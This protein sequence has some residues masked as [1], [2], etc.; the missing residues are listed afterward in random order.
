MPLCGPEAAQV[1]RMEFDGPTVSRL[2]PTVA[3]GDDTVVNEELAAGV[4]R[5]G[6]AP[7]R[8]R[9]GAKIAILAG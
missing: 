6:G 2:A 9:E 3:F 8:T 7:S 5:A 4:C 1:T